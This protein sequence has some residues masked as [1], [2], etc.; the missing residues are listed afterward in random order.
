M[1]EIDKINKLKQRYNDVSIPNRLND[2]VNDAINSKKTYKQKHTKWIVAAASL[3]VVVGSIN[4]NPV[5]ADNLEKIPVIGDLVKIINF[6]NYEVKENGYEASIKV[7]NI[8]G[9]ENKELEYKL[10]KEFEEEGKRLYNNYLEEIKLLNESNEK[11][12]K[13]AKSWYEVQ[14]D[15]DD[16]LSLVIY[17][18]EAQG[19][20]NTT[21]K[22]YNIDKNNQT[23]LTLE[24]M[25]KNDDYINVISENIKQQMREQMKSD[26]NKYYLLDD[27][28]NPETNF[29]SIKKDQQFYINKNGD[30]VISFDKYEVAPGY[31]GVVEFVIPKE[32]IKPL[33]N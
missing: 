21:R 28:M 33:V 16:I 6:S 25:F 20:S 26:K 4:I 8:Q 29:K 18:Y 12:H 5:F 14:T 22:F 2:V 3:C 13:E 1:K 7:P 15:N 9:L 17:N 23:V 11:G 19:S 10:N 32:V 31:M 30:I 24:G 27:K